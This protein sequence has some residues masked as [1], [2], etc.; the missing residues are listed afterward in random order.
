MSMSQQEK[1]DYK[2]KFNE[3]NYDR[4]GLYLKQGE[5]KCWQ[6]AADSEGISLNKFIRKCVNEKI[7]HTKTESV[8]AR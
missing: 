1:T 6:I 3:E 5:K 2:R 8:N 7:E 4:I